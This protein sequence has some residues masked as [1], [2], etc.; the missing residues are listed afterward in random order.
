MRVPDYPSEDSPKWATVD[1]Y[2]SELLAPNDE[3]LNLA[4]KHN[5]EANLPSHDVSA[6][7]GKFL[8]LLIKMTA[9]HRVLEIGT[10]GGYSTIWM[11]RALPPDGLIT[12]IEREARYVEV[13]QKNFQSAGVEQK[14]E[15]HL[16]AAA[17]VL[18]TLSGPYDLIFID[19]DKPNN[20]LYLEW[21]IK[22]SRPGT[23]I[24]ADNVVRGGEV[25]NKN[26]SNASVIGVQ[27]YMDMLAAD[28]RIDSTAL[29]TVGE[30]GW[31][32]FAIS[33][34]GENKK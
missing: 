4:L 29:Q 18:P 5:A 3:F 33:I 28:S 20:P 6:V 27:R 14:I 24:V 32:G 1:S 34:V 17:D 8:A 15:I 22:L 11:A 26:S 31:D 2:F 23:V 7:Q 30:K 16:G 13:S 19:A 25:A 12:T 21:A 10:L 9:A